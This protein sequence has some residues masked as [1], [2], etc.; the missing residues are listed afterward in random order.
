MKYIRTK[1]ELG[2]LVE[3]N[4]DI[5]DKYGNY[6]KKGCY[7]KTWFSPYTEREDIIRQAD[8]IEEL[9]DEFVIYYCDG[10][11]LITIYDDEFGFK[12]DFDYDHNLK[13][14]LERGYEIYGSVWV[15]GSLIKVAKMNE[16]GELELL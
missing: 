14:A 4:K 7:F 16:K 5:K 12:D 8:T 15:D 3:S 13:C 2:I 10:W 6:L 11:H 1:Y 9:C